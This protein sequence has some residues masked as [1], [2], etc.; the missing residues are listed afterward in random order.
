LSLFLAWTVEGSALNMKNHVPRIVSST[1]V[2][3][4][5][6]GCNNKSNKGDR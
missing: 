2:M 5:V 4:R 3:F 6:M 1:T